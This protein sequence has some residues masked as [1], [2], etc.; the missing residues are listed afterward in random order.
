MWWLHHFLFYYFIVALLFSFNSLH[1]LCLFLDCDDESS[2]ISSRGVKS[3]FLSTHLVEPWK[4]CLDHVSFLQISSVW[5]SV[6][7][8]CM[9]PKY[10][11]CHV[12]CAWKLWRK[13]QRAITSRHLF[14]IMVFIKIFLKEQLK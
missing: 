3:S 5:R 13:A 6:R 11:L 8:L 12:N 2:P 4:F 9:T 10:S 1:S 7:C 14:Q